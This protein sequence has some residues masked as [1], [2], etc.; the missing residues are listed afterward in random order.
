MQHRELV[1]PG[2]D[3]LRA[4]Q[5]EHRGEAV[6]VEVGRGPRHAQAPAGLA[7]EPQQQRDLRE[8]L[9]ARAAVVDRREVRARRRRPPRA[10]CR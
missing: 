4:L 8:R 1:Q 3:R 5:V 10:G 2:P 9:G 7:L 6:A